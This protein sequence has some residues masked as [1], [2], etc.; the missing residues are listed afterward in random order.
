M[1]TKSKSSKPKKLKLDDPKG[2]ASFAKK[3]KIS[4]P[5]FVV[6]HVVRRTS[7]GK[8]YPTLDPFYADGGSKDGSNVTTINE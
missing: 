4:T 5:F 7:D 2:W 1:K 3:K 8:Y 6:N